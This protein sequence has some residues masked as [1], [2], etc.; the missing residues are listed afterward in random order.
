MNAGIRMACWRFCFCLTAAA[1]AAQ[2]DALTNLKQKATADRAKP[3]NCVCTATI[4]QSRGVEV[5]NR[6]RLDVGYAEGVQY[7][8]WADGDSLP[9]ADVSRFVPDLVTDADL[10]ALANLLDVPGAQF[11]APIEE[12]GA[13][14]SAIR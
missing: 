1:L 4:E 6:I 9:E 13:D 7:F 11:A 10:L 5:V 2:T 14:G 12:A 3:Q 8:G